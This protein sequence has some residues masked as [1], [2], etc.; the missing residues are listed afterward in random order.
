MRTDMYLLLRNGCGVLL[1]ILGAF[2]SGVCFAAGN[3]SDDGVWLMTPDEAAM[4]APDGY[5]GVRGGAPFDIG[6]EVPNTGPSIEVITPLDGGQSQVPF[7]IVVNFSPRH[8]PVDVSTVRVH[9]VKF[10]A[11]NITKRVKPFISEQGIH[12]PDAKVPPG[13]YIVRVRVEDADGGRSV[14]N[15]SLEVM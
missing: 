11:I 1:L 8:A 15:I 13:K 6:R 7:E 9:V 2:S 12:I 5:P 4:S 14:R 3:H 10:V